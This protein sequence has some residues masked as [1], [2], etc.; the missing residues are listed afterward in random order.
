MSAD[1]TILMQWFNKHTN[2]IDMNSIADMTDVSI[3][4][5][6]LLASSKV[7]SF[8]IKEGVTTI[9]ER[10]FYNN[11]QMAISS[12]PSSLLHI[13]KDAFYNSRIPSLNL[14]NLL[15]IG[16]SAFQGNTSLTSI[17]LPAAT[18]IGDNAFANNTSLTSI[19]LP[20]A[21]TI[22]RSV[23][24]SNTSLQSITIGPNITSIGGRIFE[25][26]SQP[27]T[28]TIQATTPPRFS[29]YF[30]NQF[31]NK[32]DNITIKVPMA[33]V[34]AYKNARGWSSYSSKISGY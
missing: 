19:S 7:Q 28:L 6:G 29:G 34:E 8:T 17:N 3:I 15:T 2:S 22:E 4:A 13:E 27:I 18:T 31:D 10:A 16:N 20:A 30:N 25:G 12:L 24:F 33:S 1:G 32:N 21:T 14:P 11:P 26:T 23:F 9:E 5:S